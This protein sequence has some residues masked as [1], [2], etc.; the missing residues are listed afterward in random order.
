MLFYGY[1]WWFLRLICYNKNN[2]CKRFHQPSDRLDP[3]NG[4]WGRS[5]YVLFMHISKWILRD[6][7]PVNLWPN[8]GL[9]DLT[10]T[11]L[12]DIIWALRTVEIY[13]FWE[14]ILTVKVHDR[15]GSLT[16]K[17]LSGFSRST[18]G[19]L[20]I[21]TGRWIIGTC[22]LYSVHSTPSGIPS[23][24]FSLLLICFSTNFVVHL[25]MWIPTSRQPTRF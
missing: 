19:P 13:I 23:S 7:P 24:T 11:T 12:S 10:I 9:S 16:D 1:W 15:V 5:C 8:K 17:I 20:G 4:R 14:R 21:H 18:W 6:R 2:S 22:W 3:T 25:S